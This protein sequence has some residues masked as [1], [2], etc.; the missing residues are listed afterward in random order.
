MVICCLQYVFSEIQC[1]CNYFTSCSFYID[2]SPDANVR[3]DI[4][5]V[6]RSPHT[7]ASG[8]TS[9]LYSSLHYVTGELG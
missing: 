3:H 4:G 6:S 9:L 1:I 2:L 7:I 8:C 5:E